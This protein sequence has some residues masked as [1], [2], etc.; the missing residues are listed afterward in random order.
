MSET[1]GHFICCLF[2]PYL[3]TPTVHVNLTEDQVLA[4]A[5]DE[6]SKKAGKE[7]ANSAKWVTKG[8]TPGLLW[9]ECQGSGS[10][11]YQTAVDLHS[12][13]FKCSC[14]SRK[15]P[16]KHGVA[17][18]VLYARRAADFAT[19]EPPVWAAE[20]LNKRAEKE[21]KVAAK[22]EAPVDEAA[23]AKRR[24]AREGKA[25]EGVSDLLLWLQDIVR[26]GIINMPDKPRTYWEGAA[27]RLVDAQVPG[28]AG[29]VKSLADTP[30]YK[31]GWQSS[32]LG[33]LLN[34]YLLAKGFQN[35]QALTN[36]LLHDVRAGLGFTVPQEEL[37]AGTGVQDTWLVLGKR[38]SEE[39]QITVER[40]WLW[41]ASTNRYALVLQFLVRGQGATLVL[42]PG[43]WV[44]AEL[45]YYP[46]V[47]PLRAVVKQYSTAAAAPCFS[48]LS[49]WEEVAQKQTETCAAFPVQ[50]NRPYVV[51]G[52]KPIRYTDG[53]WLQDSQQRM[54]R[55]AENFPGIW[56]LL[57]LSGGA[58]LD[59]AVVGKGSEYEPLGV[60][61][62]GSYKPL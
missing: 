54:V 35:R 9:G 23:Q 33:N 40:F 3:P 34:I 46:S 24:Q 31:E 57:A 4:L 56:N 30:F 32:F 44:D 43:S 37:K 49:G 18:G 17:L 51:S 48:L 58:A 26:T 11:P 53:W 22:K 7:L 8:A 6:A 39:E 55:I 2:R 10:K 45:V 19:A 13:A 25:D 12:L 62:S 29:M 52:I 47:S 20:W 14:P 42:A 50:S 5:P 28:L 41:G 38:V 16:C 27:K 59:V 15:F 60:W 61:W 1:C 36:G 21:E